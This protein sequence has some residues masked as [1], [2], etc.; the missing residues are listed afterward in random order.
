MATLL[1]RLVGRG[2]AAGAALLRP[3]AALPFDDLAGTPLEAVADNYLAIITGNRLFSSTGSALVLRPGLA[4]S[5]AHVVGRIPRVTALGRRGPVELRLLRQSRWMD[6][7]LL[8]VDE[9]F[10][11]VLTLGRAA[12]GQPVWSMGTTSRPWLPPIAAGRVETDRATAWLAAPDGARHDG[13]M[14]AAEAGPGYSGGPVVDAAGAL[15]GLTEG[16]YV[17][18]TGESPAAWP[19]LPRLFA[20]HAAAVAAEAALLQMQT[21]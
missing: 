13:L 17:D 2:A 21:I 6:L 20:Y 11:R 16:I 4:V 1:R 7:A 15:V 12:P 18:L 3:G 10:G 14:Y 19:R 9:P 8:A 5:S